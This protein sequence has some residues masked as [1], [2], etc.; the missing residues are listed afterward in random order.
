MSFLPTPR[1]ALIAL[2]AGLCLAPAAARADAVPA[3]WQSEFAAFAHADEARR[4]G[5]GGVVFVGSS[6]IRLWERLADAF[7]RFPTIVQRGFGGST[8]ADCADNVARLVTPYR[9]RVVVLYAGENDLAEGA[10]PADVVARVRA[11]TERVRSEQPA[12]HIAYVSIKPSPL[13]AGLLADIRETN[14]RIREYLAT[15]PDTQFIDVHTPMLDA[16][17]RPR[18]ELFGA[19]RLHMNAAG[20]ALWRR[21][22]NARL[23]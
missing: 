2:L 22:I 1:R 9:P 16:D 21:E 23:P 7:E 17:G 6:S 15:V 11:F 19:D 13:R 14:A 12:V 8:A 3:R 5:P 18:A 20:Y 10:A 4:P